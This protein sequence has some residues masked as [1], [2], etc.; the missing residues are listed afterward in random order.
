[1][2][3]LY[4]YAYQESLTLSAQLD[5]KVCCSLKNFGIGPWTVFFA[6]ELII[7]FDYPIT[8]KKNEGQCWCH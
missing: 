5:F 1:M 6:E 7:F 8:L 4:K 3:A 2:G